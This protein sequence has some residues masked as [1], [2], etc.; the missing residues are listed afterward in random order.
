MVESSTQGTSDLLALSGVVRESPRPKQ[1]GGRIIV[2]LPAFNEEQNLGPLLEKIDSQLS[3]ANLPFH[4]IVVDDGSTDRTPS[5][6]R[7]FGERIPVTSLRHPVNLGLGR[8]IIDGLRA[9]GDIAGDEDVVISMDADETHPPGLMPRM[10]R[11]IREGHDVVIASRYRQGSRVCG[12]SAGRRLTSMAASI[13]A[14][15]AFPTPGVRDFT[16]GYRAYSGKALRLAF[17]E[18]GNSL[19]DQPG[20]PCMID[21]LLKMRRLPL[22]FGEVPMVLRYDFKKGPSKLPRVATIKSTLLLLLRSRLGLSGKPRARAPAG[23]AHDRKT[24]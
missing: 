6:I 23:L 12:L 8:T 15:V 7:S 10:F 3:E 17:R 5:I 2:V 13:V 1:G 21:I 20:F 14:R 11:A 18:Y 22:V 16:C 24:A 19:V 4:I 9:A